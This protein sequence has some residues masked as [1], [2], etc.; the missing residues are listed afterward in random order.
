M[1]RFAEVCEAVAAT[2]S[3]TRKSI[4]V[5]NY[6]KELAGED[7]R[8]AALYLTGAA[9]PGR[10]RRGLSIGGATL[11]EAAVRATGYP[12]PVVRLC[13][14]ETGDTAE[15]MALL[16]T[17]FSAS[18]PLSLEQASAF[19]ERLHGARTAKDKIELI[20]GF[21][22]RHRPAAL[23]YALK[24][25]TGSMR[26][27]LQERLVREA[28]EQ[29]GL[30]GALPEF[31]PGLNSPIAF[32]LAKPLEDPASLASPAEWWI[33]DKYDGIRCQAHLDH[34]RLR[35]FTRSLEEITMSFPDLALGLQTVP[36]S[37]VLDGELLAWRDGRALPFHVLQQRLARKRIPPKLMEEIPVTLLVYDVL[38]HNGTL[39]LDWPLERRREVLESLPLALA[40]RFR[41]GSAAE[42]E[43]R[44]AEA[45]ARGNEGL[46]LK[47]T[48]SPYEAGKRSGA[49][50]KLKRPYATLDVVITAAE[51][52]RGRRATVLS[53][54]TFAVRDGGRFVNVG[55]AYSGLTDEEIRALT[56]LLRA[57][58]TQRFGRVTLVEPMVVLEV[59]FD[60]IQRSPRH[61]S[62]FALRFPRI[63]RWRTDKQAREADT[64]ERVQAL[65][66]KTEP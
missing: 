3:R 56:R 29:A 23:K 40:P 55:K 49:W 6:L 15:A 44:F 62:G 61:K 60:G 41:A 33:E 57:H 59:A 2:G 19:Y 38:F 65:F 8:R 5:Q 48:G 20:A 52:G 53:D 18:E 66:E 27:G 16:M 13:L 47:R 21:L 17:P 34:G 12:D 22:L 50:L 39:T 25:I 32:M 1:D 10:T 30:T 45:R 31:A 37:M 36:G 4:L 64:L 42:I 43:Q 63:L 51:Q 58:A 54:Y 35:L 26:I 7:L 14:R 46:V 9:L 28:V 24:V 11:R